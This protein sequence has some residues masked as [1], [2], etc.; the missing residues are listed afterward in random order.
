MR[1]FAQQGKGRGGA[2]VPDGA[3]RRRRA[4][5]RLSGG[6]GCCPVV[7]TRER[8]RARVT[9]RGEWEKRQG[10]SPQGQTQAVPSGSVCVWSHIP[11]QIYRC[12]YS[13]FRAKRQAHSTKKKIVTESLIIFYSTRQKNIKLILCLFSSLINC[14]YLKSKKN[15][16]CL[17]ML[18][19][20]HGSVF[21][22]TSA[23][24][25]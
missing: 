14:F 9:R 7:G 24:T 3:R 15:R 5:R 22:A 16:D 11:I 20:P 23:L 17:I 8:G 21:L 25:T 2:G 4:R 6:G 12:A 18:G 10:R 19:S 13:L 1:G